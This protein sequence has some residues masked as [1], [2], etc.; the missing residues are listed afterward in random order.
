M[1]LRGDPSQG[2]GRGF[3]VLAM[4]FVLFIVI[5]SMLA[6]VGLTEYTAAILFAL[7]TLVTFVAIGFF[8]RTMHLPDFLISSREVPPAFNGMATAA[9]FLASAGFLGLTAAFFEGNGTVLAVI[10]GWALGFLA[11]SILIAPYF[12]K[13]AAVTVADFLAVR[14]DN[15]AVRFAAV[16]VTL[17]SCFGFLVAEMNAA[18]L[19]AASFLGISSGSGIIIAVVVTVAASLFGGMRAVTLTA[20]AQYIVIAIAFLTP[21]A[22]VSFYDYDIP[23]PQ[24]TYGY[25][26]EEIAALGGSPLTVT[27]SRLLPLPVLDGFNTVVLILSLAAGVASMPHILMRSG[28]S[29]GIAAARRSAGWAL[30]FILVV[31]ATAPAYA[32]FAHLALLGGR[33]VGPF[34]ADAVV[35][36]LPTIA[37]LSPAMSALVAA[38][39]LAAIL[40]TATALLFAIATTIGHDLFAGILDRHGPPGRRLIVTR[41]VLIAV[42]GLA[43]WYAMSATD[44]IFVLATTSLSLAASGLFPALVLG[45]WWKR[46][47]AWGAFAGVVLGF[48]A[49]A[50][51]VFMVLYGGMAPW[52]PL[53]TAGTGLP[54]MA[55]AFFGIPV[56]ILTIV[57]VS[58][59][60]AEPAARQVKLVE[61]IRQPAPSPIFDDRSV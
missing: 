60:T 11:L 55:A 23:V 47:T 27:S 2:F 25:A 57:F 53:G 10:A 45:I 61:A 26:L 19:V 51:Y 17:A 29:T 1:S 43:A 33:S 32:A 6:E 4:S 42:A 14:F 39:A 9:A 50:A 34:E 21:V 44:D 35:L 48:S 3:G 30:F 13:A 16:V 5:V 36:A 46:A 52:Q 59:I 54:A 24:L 8:A 20:I 22:L 15:S 56:G 40:A 41:V 18:G 31:V 38:G 28:T 12:R 37:E 49:A 7:A 58:Q